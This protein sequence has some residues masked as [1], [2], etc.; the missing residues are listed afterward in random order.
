MEKYILIYDADCGPC[1]R[2]KRAI[3]WLD[4]YDH[5]CYVS[6]IGADGRGLL[7]SLPLGQ[8]H[9]SFHLIS[10]DGR[11]RSASEAI[12]GLLALL[13]LGGI[14][15]YLIR[16][17]PAGMRAVYFIYSIFSR[18]HNNTGSCAFK[19]HALSGSVDGPASDCIDGS[20]ER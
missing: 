3:D 18:L 17:A 10:P 12:P 16:T 20:P 11:I 14:A 15:A 5:L 2:F 8:R 7:D 13:P 19:Q 6:L 1:T 9:T 4:R